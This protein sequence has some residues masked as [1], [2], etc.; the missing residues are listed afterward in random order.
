MKLEMLEVECKSIVV[1]DW[2]LSGYY[3]QWSLAL[4]HILSAKQQVSEK[5]D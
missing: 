3:L 5:Y 1:A 2:K 4:L